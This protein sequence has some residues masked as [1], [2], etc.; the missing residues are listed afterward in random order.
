MAEYLLLSLDAYLLK[1]IGDGSLLSLGF[2]LV[3][4]RKQNGFDTLNFSPN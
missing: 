1:I 4:S 2:I 3:F